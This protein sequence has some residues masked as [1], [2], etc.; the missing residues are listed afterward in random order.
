MRGNPNTC[1]EVWK[2]VLGENT[3]EL[4][5]KGVRSV[6][7]NAGVDVVD[8]TGYDT[9]PMCP[10]VLHTH[11]P[12]IHWSA[13]THPMCPLVYHM[14]MP[15]VHWLNPT[16]AFSPHPSSP[17]TPHLWVTQALDRILQ[18]TDKGT[19]NTPLSI[20]KSPFLEQHPQ[21]PHLLATLG[22][23]TESHTAMTESQSSSAT[24]VTVCIRYQTLIKCMFSFLICCGLSKVF[25]MR[26]T[27]PVFISW[28]TCLPSTSTATWLLI[29]CPYGEC[30][31]PTPP[32]SL[33]AQ[34]LISHPDCVPASLNVCPLPWP[35]LF[36]P[37]HSSPTLTVSLWA[38]A[39][40]SHLNCSFRL[41]CS[42][43]P[44]VSI[45][46][47]MLATTLTVSPQAQMLVSHLSHVILSLN[48]Q[49]PPPLCPFKLEC[50]SPA[51]P[52]HF[53]PECLFPIPTV[54]IQAWMLASYPNH[55]PSSSNAHL[56][57]WLC[58]CKPKHLSSAPTISIQARV[59]ISCL[60]CVISSPNAHLPP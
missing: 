52:C 8:C 23:H 27:W 54:S 60:H 48:A 59:L 28:P 11:T 10:L 31:L 45:R 29:L 19:P 1:P 21:P 3:P 30:L 13:I 26:V 35:Y 47:W 58:P 32:V 14:L 2:W 16:H 18:L 40:I 24:V 46:A 51:Q 5:S 25:A 7:Q 9:S 12:C 22:Q 42:L 6:D 17:C 4:V 36:E 55:F 50:S 57:P 15:C 38:W 39:L 41:K 44:I 49:S 37:K 43:T 34:M 53:E 20:S 56:L 33:W